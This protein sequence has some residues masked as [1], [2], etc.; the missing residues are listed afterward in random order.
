MKL[1][2]FVI[3]K[4]ERAS[5]RHTVQSSASLLE[6]V[7]LSFVLHENGRKGKEKK[8]QRDVWEKEKHK[9]S[10]D[11]HIHS[12]QWRHVFTDHW[13]SSAYLCPGHYFFIAYICGN[14]S[15][16]TSELGNFQQDVTG[17][18]RVT[19]TIS[20]KSIHTHLC[21]KPIGISPK[22]ATWTFPAL[23][24]PR[25]CRSWIIILSLRSWL[26]HTTRPKLYRLEN[27]SSKLHRSFSFAINDF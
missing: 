24:T 4:L 27:Y 21:R 7:R 13:P 22:L 5:N 26:V 10:S 6:C 19:L 23:S 20:L 9:K 18:M 15:D 11:K 17:S 16:M 12:R 8:N 1:Y 2:P 14:E 25:N 3:Y